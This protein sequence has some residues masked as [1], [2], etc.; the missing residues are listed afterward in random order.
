MNSDYILN[1]LLGHLFSKGVDLTMTEAEHHI[2]EKE[3]SD[4]LDRFDQQFIAE[5]DAQITQC[6][7]DMQSVIEKRLILVSLAEKFIYQDNAGISW[8][9]KQQFIETASGEIFGHA[10]WRKEISSKVVGKYLNYFFD[11]V[12]M[13]ETC[14]NPKSYRAL[15]NSYAN[16]Q[17]DINQ[18]HARRITD[19]ETITRGS[20]DSGLVPVDFETYYKDV[21]RKFTSKKRG[22]YRNLVGEE[23]DETS[24]IEAFITKEGEQI[25]VLYYLQEWFVK[26]EPGVILIHGEPGHGKTMLCSKASFEFYKGRFLKDKAKNVVAVSLNTGKNPRIVKDGKVKLSNALTFGADDEYSFSFKDCLGSLL[27]LD[28]F[29][30]FIDEAK[31][32]NIENIC[33]F[34]E[35]VDDIADKYKMHIVV[36]SRTIAVSRDLKQLRGSY[37]YYKISPITDEQHNNWLDQHKEYGDYREAFNILRSD[38]NMQK[39]LR[40]PFLFRL[41]VNSRFETV[42]SNIVELYNN[43]FI[44]LMHKRDIYYDDLETV[45]EGLMSLA[46]EI[47]C[48]DTNMAKVDWD[49]RWIFAFYVE[50]VDGDRIGFFHRTFYQY[51]LA[52]YI[53]S[54]I[55]N[56]TDNNV[57]DFIG[58]FA[59][60]EL[61]DTVCQ[62][63]ALMYKK[64]DKSKVFPNI[65]KMINALVSTEAF[66]NFIPHVKTGDAERSKILRS[67][68]VYRNTLNIA[69][70]VSYVIQIPFKGTLDLLVKTFDSKEIM[71]YSVKNKRPDL[72]G[73][74]LRGSK[75]SRAHLSRSIL[76]R[77]DLDG[78]NLSGA[79]LSRADLGGAYMREANM[80]G[81]NLIKADL[82]GA[83]LSG[84]DMIGANLRG[85]DLRNGHLNGAYLIRADLRGADLSGVNLSNADLRGA[86][87]SGAKMLFTDLSGS[88]LSGADLSGIDIGYSGLSR[89]N[90]SGA[91]LREA[92]IDDY[93]KF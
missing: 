74:D 61:D 30:E 89:V 52:K 81:T 70:A 71:L 31:Q 85:A 59:E 86:N 73:A 66:L 18:N 92:I 57:E 72:F 60:R 23:P 1:L 44:H 76:S 36:L 38:E 88:D 3:F 11:I 40:V 25:P 49:T 20:Q 19:L 16:N 87:L 53:Y 4:I 69:M 65:G 77:A 13:K 26:T 35:L 43:L 37:K 10:E 50:S 79:D 9:L 34:L 51:F 12:F 48:T 28:G 7:C 17:H 14:K 84:A 39:L 6:Q 8:N 58:L 46:F 80:R 24:Y 75:L 67:T 68:N 41:I 63:L 5:N 15:L 27:F 2:S 78:A 91:N 29:D 32:A 55:I 64:E 45:K 93:I 33:S 47:Y 62:Y 56:I 54:G 22:E 42:T 21:E 83:H 90:L 82:R